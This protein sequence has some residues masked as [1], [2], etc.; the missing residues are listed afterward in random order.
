MKEESSAANRSAES[1]LN[2]GGA[3]WLAVV[4]L[5]ILLTAGAFHPLET[6]AAGLFA[7]AAKVDITDRDAPFNDPL[8]AKA[9][10]LKDDHTIAV[11][12]TVDAVAIG[13]IGRI[14]NDFLQNVRARLTK[15]LNI[16]PGNVLINASHCHGV[17]CSDVVER[18]EQ[19]IKDAYRKL[20]PV[21]VGAGRGRENRIMENRRVRL[22]D[23]TQADMRRA[24]ALPADEQV[25]A[26]GPVDPEIGILRIDRE[27][28]QTLAVVYNFAC[29]PI[30]GVPSGLNTA[31]FPGFASK[32]IEENLAGDALAFFVQ[33]CGGDINPAAYKSVSVPH[34]AEPLGNLL[35]LSVL[36]AMKSTPTMSSGELKIHSE[37][38]ALP[39]AADYERRIA[40]IQNEQVTALQS[41]KGTNINLKTY[42]PLLIQ[43]KLAVDFSSDF[44][45]RF[46]QERAMGRDD[47]LK[48]DAENRANLEQ[49]TRNI[50]VMEQLTR[51]QTNLDLLKKHQAQ[52]LAAGKAKLEVE[53]A[54]L[55]VGNFTMVTF[56][57][58]LTVEIGLSIKKS[59]PHPFTFV[60]GYTNGYIYYTPTEQQRNNSG[61][62]QEDCDCLVAPEWRELFESK[63]NAILKK[64]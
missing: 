13:E 40:A 57:G 4:L 33:G 1:G 22:K 38:I 51:L 37:V 29:H 9:L 11:L 47:L 55:R 16:P 53:V 48:L 10:V 43:Y 32:V 28:G 20:E 46:L 36:R 58:E 42:V 14:R 6:N 60:A 17:I 56:P 59:S 12:V 21:R 34:D 5:L 18:T 41:L 49:Y 7:G 61:F 2:R 31:D 63:A 26:I 35:G 45:Y 8:Y 25:T 44:S 64:L 30:Q 52:T 62:A 39:R 24:Y 3:R 15:Q 27:N 54:G 19:A 23:G 50:L